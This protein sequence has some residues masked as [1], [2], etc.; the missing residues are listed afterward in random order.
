MNATLLARS[1]YTT[2]STSMRAP[3]DT[4]YAAFARATSAL[5]TAGT[6]SERAAAINKNRE[7]WTLLACD[8]ASPDNGLP[9]ELRARIFYLAE[10]TDQHSSKVLRGDADLAALVEINTAI[11]AGLR[12][13]AT[14][15]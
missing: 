5:K 13:P 14:V 9:A 6:Y 2:S 4:E 10:F 3:R 7:L 12:T 11:M 8:V 1:A 15:S